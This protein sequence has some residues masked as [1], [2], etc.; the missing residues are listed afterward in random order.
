LVDLDVRHR[1]LAELL[2][3][4][5]RLGMTDVLSGEA[6]VL[7]VVRDFAV[8]RD[9]YMTVLYG[10]RR[11]ARGSSERRMVVHEDLDRL[12][13]RYD[14]TVIVSDEDPAQHH[15]LL[16]ATDV[17]LCV[18]ASETPVVWLARSAQQVRAEGHRL[19]AV[20]LWSANAS[21]A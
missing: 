21:V 7:E 6:E 17:I 3:V 11:A 20:L 19:R 15:A 10:G 16:P 1:H 5:S 12:S 8:G 2:R 9:V 14:L 13:S 4:D 18:K